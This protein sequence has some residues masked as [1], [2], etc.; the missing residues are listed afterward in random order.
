MSAGSHIVL[1][2]G[3]VGVEPQRKY[4]R[5]GRGTTTGWSCGAALR[6]QGAT[7]AR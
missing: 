5:R 3:L 2:R 6:N 7:S 1:I 4:D